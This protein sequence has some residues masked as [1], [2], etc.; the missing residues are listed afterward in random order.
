MKIRRISVGRRWS[1]L[2]GT[3]PNIAR[4][5]ERTRSRRVV[6]VV[7]DRQR[8]VAAANARISR[9]TSEPAGV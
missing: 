3:T 4:Q 9:S 8:I 5:E 2:S 1:P 7:I 6:R